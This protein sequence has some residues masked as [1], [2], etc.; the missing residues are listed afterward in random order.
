MILRIDCMTRLEIGDAMSRVR[1]A[2]ARANGR[3]ADH[4]LIDHKLAE[5]NIWLPDRG[6]ETFLDRLPELA[7]YVE[8]A[9]SPDRVRGR[10]VRCHLALSFEAA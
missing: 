4:K 8:N 1:D 9:V 6:F 10:E 3:I 7:V 5:F 2:I